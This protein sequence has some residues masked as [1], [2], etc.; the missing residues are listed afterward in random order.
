MV[1]VTSASFLKWFQ[2]SKDVAITVA[3]WGYYII[4]FLVLFAPFYLFE[5]LVSR[6]VARSFQRLNSRF[7]RSFF[8]LLRA[9]VPACRWQ[10]DDAVG[11]IR[12][13]VVVANHLSYLDPILLISLFPRHTTIAKRRFFHIPVYGRLVRLS[14]YLP[15]S[16]DG[17]LADLMLARMEQMPALFADGG[18]LVIFPEGTR[19]RDGHIGAFNTGAFKIARLCNVPIDVVHMQ[20]TAR[21]F[22]PGRFLFD[23][24]SSNTISVQHLTR[25]EPR[26]HDPDFSLKDLMAEVQD[27]L[28]RR[29]SLH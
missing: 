26:Y 22:K 5:W 9:V 10:V 29:Q 28:E 8:I 27:L 24:R 14:G 19:S 7:Y 4:G 18:N 16:S 23:T 6:D 21:L 13:S 12:G 3:L 11:A 1:A 20:G 25:I 2:F 15:S 17:R